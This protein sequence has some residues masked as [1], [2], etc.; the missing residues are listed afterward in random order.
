MKIRLCSLNVVCHVLSYPASFLRKKTGFP[1]TNPLKYGIIEE[2]EIKTP[3]IG[4]YIIVEFLDHV[5]NE[6][7]PAL[8]RATGRV[9]AVEPEFIKLRS[10]ECINSPDVDSITEWCIIRS[11]IRHITRLTQRGIRPGEPRGTK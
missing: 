6:P 3:N 7:I 2:V 5:E 1:L 11:T 9:T 4:S 8:I 10:W